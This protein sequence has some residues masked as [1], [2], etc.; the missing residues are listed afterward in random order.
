[1]QPGGT[2]SSSA[3]MGGGMSMPMLSMGALASGG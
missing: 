2:G 3:S 1:L